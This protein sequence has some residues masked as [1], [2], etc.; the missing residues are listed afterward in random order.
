MDH[1]A[2][3]RV[4]PQTTANADFVAPWACSLFAALGSADASLY[5]RNFD[6]DHSPAL[7]LFADP[8]GGFASVSMVDIAYLVSED[9]LDHLTELP[10]AERTELLDTISR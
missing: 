10:L 3:D 9:K 4:V 6:W 8:P 2:S 5:G 1:T 7:M